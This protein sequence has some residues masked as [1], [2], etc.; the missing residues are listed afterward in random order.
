MSWDIN[1]F[2][3]EGHFYRGPQKDWE[4]F[5]YGFNPRGLG[6]LIYN[7]LRKI[8]ETNDKSHWAYSAFQECADLLVYGKRWPD[9]LNPP[10][11]PGKEPYR[12]QFSVTRDPFIALW[13]CA[14]HLN[15]KQFIKAKPPRKLYSPEVWAWRRALLG[16]RNCYKFF[17]RITPGRRN[18]VKALDDLM[19]NAYK[20]NRER[21]Q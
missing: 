16:K 15:R 4:Y 7:T 5:L 10:N 12:S 19:W 14:I 3:K 18:F 6:D 8:I 11:I 21:R 2:Y 9:E 17:R 1:K 20:K 13:A